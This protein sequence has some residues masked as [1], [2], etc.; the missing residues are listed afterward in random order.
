MKYGH[1]SD[2]KNNHRP[3]EY[4]K[5]CLVIRKFTTK[6]VPELSDAVEASDIDKN[7]GD[8]KTYAMSA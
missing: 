8:E 5:R 6:T 2:C 4:H 1:R 7:S 3:L